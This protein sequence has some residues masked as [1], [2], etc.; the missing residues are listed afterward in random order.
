MTVQWSPKF[1]GRELEREGAAK[2]SAV[3]D[4]DVCSEGVEVV[5]CGLFSLSSFIACVLE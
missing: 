4:S 5:P 3:H 1:R 2:K